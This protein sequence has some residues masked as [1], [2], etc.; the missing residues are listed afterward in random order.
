MKEFT[1]RSK[2]VLLL[3]FFLSCVCYA[4]VR[5]CLYTPCGHL[6][7]KG[8]PLGPRLWCRL[9]VSFKLSHWY[10]RSGVV[11]DCIDS[12]PLHLY[13]IINT[14]WRL[15]VILDRGRR[16][17]YMY[18]TLG[19]ANFH[20]FA[21]TITAE[22]KNN[23]VRQFCALFLYFY[24]VLLWKHQKAFKDNATS[25]A[26]IYWY[27]TGKCIRRFAGIYAYCRYF[28]DRKW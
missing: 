8:L 9:T 22:Q 4:F 26:I 18:K 1:D 11:L 21:R 20:A 13:L 17:L 3:C 23:N 16:F 10:P 7:E 28:I 25:A 27:H 15:P 24:P 12:W 14:V 19:P 2:A 6:L 5:V